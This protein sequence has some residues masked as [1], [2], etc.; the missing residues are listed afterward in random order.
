MRKAS[1][2]FTAAV[3]TIAVA[4]L[5]IAGLD[6]RPLRAG[7][8]FDSPS[9]LK[10][11]RTDISDVYIFPAQKKKRET[12]LIMTVAPLAGLS[13]PRSSTMRPTTSSTSTTTATSR[14]T[15]SGRWPSMVTTC[16]S[17]SMA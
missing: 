4:A 12:T 14:S 7:D 15:A 16:R 1:V 17:A 11:G 3:P 5:V 13:S 6:V 9:V 8:H 2:V 10:D